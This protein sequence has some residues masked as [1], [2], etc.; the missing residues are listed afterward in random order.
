MEGVP[1]K[2]KEKKKKKPSIVLSYWFADAEATANQMGMCVCFF[3]NL[4]KFLFGDI[5]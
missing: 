4:V 5:W 3:R 1:T 2:N